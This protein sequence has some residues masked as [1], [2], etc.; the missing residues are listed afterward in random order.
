MKFALLGAD[1]TTVAL[2]RTIVDSP[3][4]E[5]VWLY[6]LGEIEA[7]L[8]SLA[9]EAKIARHWEDVLDASLADVVLV[10]RAEDDDRTEALKK[11]FQA[12]I[13]LL[14]AHPVHDSLLVY[15]ELDMIT[16]DSR[17]QVL[18]F[19]P[20]RWHPAV[21]RLRELCDPATADRDEPTLGKLEQ[22]VCERAM[23]ERTERQVLSRF[24]HDAD[25]LRALAGELNKVGAMTPTGK[26]NPNQYAN[27]GIKM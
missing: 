3:E 19:L 27:L 4:H 8:R 1:A 20:G 6:G 26:D 23:S 11:V 18:P 25:L 2:A 22:V 5:I 17:T 10:A 24:V 15:Y 21:E 14:L 7:E 12:G 13:P 9:P 16:R